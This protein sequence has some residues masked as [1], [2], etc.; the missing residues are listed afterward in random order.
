VKSPRK[1][2]ADFVIC[3]A[4]GIAMQER[5]L[6]GALDAAKKAAGL[7]GLDE[8]LSWHSLRHSFA[9]LLATDLELPATTLARLTG[10]AD[11]GFTLKVYAR[12]GRDDAAVVEDVLT[13]AAGAGIGSNGHSYVNSLWVVAA[14]GGQPRRLTGCPTCTD[15]EATWSPNGQLLLFTRTR[16]RT[17]RL[18]TVRPDGSHLTEIAD[19]A[20]PQWSPDGRRIAFDSRRRGGIVVANA[21]G[22]DARLLFAEKGATGPGVPS[23]SPDGRKLLYV[24][25]PPARGGL[26]YRFE[27]WTINAD[28]SAKKRLY[29]TGCCIMDW[30][31]P[32]W[33]PDGRLIAF[34]AHTAGGTFVMNADGTGLRRL[35]RTTAGLAWQ[36]L[37]KGRRK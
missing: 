32:I 1:R 8:R 17:E 33:S 24:K 3:T 28:G 11:A 18:Y 36:P 31:G 22:S 35:S 2:P 10:H 29:H 20:D 25:T 15:V 26:G 9:S 37:P 12:D 23:W 6:R 30:G 4:E 13:R 16:G 21:D 19:G 34:S 14:A 27:I 5:N 7:D